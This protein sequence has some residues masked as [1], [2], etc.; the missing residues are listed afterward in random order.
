[1]MKPLKLTISIALGA[2]VGLLVA[3]GGSSNAADNGPTMAQFNALKQ[4]VSA[5]ADAKSTL[6]DKVASL[7]KQVDKLPT[8]DAAADLY[9]TIQAPNLDHKANARARAMALGLSPRDEKVNPCTTLGTLTGH[10][11]TSSPITSRNLAGVSCTGYLFTISSATAEGTGYIQ[12]TNQFIWYTGP[13]CTGDA[14]AYLTPIAAANGAV[15]VPSE[16]DKLSTDPKD[17]LYLP[18]GEAL[19]KG[20]EVLSQLNPNGGHDCSTFE[21]PSPNNLYKLEINDPSIT[22]VDSAPVP[23]PVLMAPPSSSS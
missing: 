13:N 15:F 9:L 19:S 23:G 20:V 11:D 21:S 12:P 17:Y 22:G 3:C 10:P 18:Q 16:G 5:L 14:Y 4:Q 2:V 8:T 1:M 7:Q 6:Q